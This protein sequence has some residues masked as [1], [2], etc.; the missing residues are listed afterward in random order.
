MKK[1]IP[2]LLFFFSITCLW[3][4]NDEKQAFEKAD[5]IKAGQVVPNFSFMGT[6]GERISFAKYKGKVS[7]IAFFATW[8][9]PCRMELPHIEKEI[10]DKYRYKKNFSLF[11]F[12]REHSM[13]E[14]TKFKNDNHYTMPFYADPQREVY[15]KFA[16]N[17]IPRIYLINSDGKVTYTTT[18][19]NE[20]GFHKLLDLL[21]IMLK[22]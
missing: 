3:A 15:S 22:K 4:Q 19:Y 13:V 21:Q 8:C 7:V 6:S 2:L 1:I 17:Y 20:A 11:I 16:K 18:G 9:G 5:I 12:G 10:W 14:V